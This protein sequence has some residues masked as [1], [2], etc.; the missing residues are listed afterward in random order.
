MKA[1]EHSLF[2][3]GIYIKS[4]RFDVNGLETAFGMSSPSLDT[5]RTLSFRPLDVKIIA[6]YKR[7]C[8]E[9]A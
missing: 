9:N 7:K 1:F 5:P 4:M 6:E 3:T 2:S 8:L